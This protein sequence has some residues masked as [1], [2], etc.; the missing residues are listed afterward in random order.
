LSSL[1]TILAVN[2][3]YYHFVRGTR[4]IGAGNGI[5]ETPA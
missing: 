2:S 3:L 4:P 1:S 5:G